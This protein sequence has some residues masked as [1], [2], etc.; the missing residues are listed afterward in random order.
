VSWPRQAQDM[1][2]ERLRKGLRCPL[3]P[4]DPACRL[5]GKLGKKTFSLFAPFILKTIILPRQARDKHRKSRGKKRDRFL[6]ESMAKWDWNCTT[7][8]SFAA[9][10]SSRSTAAAASSSS[11][12]SSSSS[13]AASTRAHDDNDGSSSASR[14]VLGPLPSSSPLSPPPPP[15]WNG[16]CSHYHTCGPPT[17]P[18]NHTV[19]NVLIIGDSISDSVS[20]ACGTVCIARAPFPKSSIQNTCRFTKPGSGQ[21]TRQENCP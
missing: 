4:R 10:L 9:N 2:Q 19:P 7:C 18:L 15:P 16:P 12:S 5:F 13:A 20:G 6:A 11:S 21:N 3:Q 8:I 1:H 17:T 14:V